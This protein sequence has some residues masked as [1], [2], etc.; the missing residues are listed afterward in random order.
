[1]ADLRRHVPLPRV[2]RLGVVVSAP[3]AAVLIGLVLGGWLGVAPALCAFLITYLALLLLLRPL[4]GDLMG[5]AFY[6]RSEAD[7]DLQARPPEIRFSETGRD[8]VVAAYTLRA[9]LRR[10][11]AQAETQADFHGAVARN[12]PIP[13]LIVSPDRVV[14]RANAAAAAV[15]GREPETK[16]LA[17]IIRDPGAL[18]AVDRVLEGGQ[19]Q[20]VHLTLGGTVERAFDVTVEPLPDTGE[21]RQAMI[22]LHDVTPLVRA[23]QMRADFVANASHELRTPLTSV[24]GF[25]ETLRGP[26][27]DDTEAHERFLG[28]MYQQAVRMKRLIE[29]L[30]SLSR[31]ELHEHTQ[32]TDSVDLADVVQAITEGMLL[33]IQNKAMTLITD[34]PETLPPVLGDPDELA[35]VVQNLLTNAVKYGLD[36]TTVTITARQAER[37]PASMPQSTRAD[38][39][40]LT[41]RDQGEG[42]AKEHLPR[43]TER[44]YRVDTARSRQLGGTGLG[45]AIVKH[46]VNRHRGALAIDSAVGE[47]S[48]FSVFLPRFDRPAP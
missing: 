24:L 12:L 39:V 45:L 42:I 31:I 1:M 30:L 2:M 41:V 18:E 15:M 23:E 17:T 32:P 34:I 13:L 11:L 9:R 14:L 43:L 33:Q 3:Y 36:G 6:L 7:D 37:G 38:C 47:G 19:R 29:D 22:L 44:F 25:I 28:I 46:I 40:M 16:A 48:A 20:T 5:V 27:R 21:G 26:A 10:R 35:Q 4:M 8:V